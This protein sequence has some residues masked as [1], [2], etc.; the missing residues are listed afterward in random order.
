MTRLYQR[1]IPALIIGRSTLPDDWNE[2][3]EREEKRGPSDGPHRNVDF[4][5]HRVIFE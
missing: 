2:I 5:G 4:V 3:G 1:L